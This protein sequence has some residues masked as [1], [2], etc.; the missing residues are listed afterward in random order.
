MLMQKQFDVTIIFKRG[1]S[2]GCRFYATS[3]H[4][5]TAQ[6]ITWARQSGFLG[7]IKKAEIIELSSS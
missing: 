7:A 1:G 6:A 2:F 3:K 4:A 5:A